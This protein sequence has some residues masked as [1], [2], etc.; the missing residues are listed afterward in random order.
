M[1]SR[2]VDIVSRRSDVSG[3]YFLEGD[4]EYKP[5]EDLATFLKGGEPPIYIG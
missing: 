1:S 3:F 4:S 5:D 2:S